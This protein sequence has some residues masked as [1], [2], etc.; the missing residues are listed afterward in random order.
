MTKLLADVSGPGL[1]GVR[2]RV[3]SHTGG[4]AT[5]KE[6]YSRAVSAE[7]VA[8]VQVARDPEA[9]YVL[10]GCDPIPEDPERQ[11]VI[12]TSRA[13]AAYARADWIDAEGYDSETGPSLA[14]D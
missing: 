12:R 11:A 7:P 1:Y 14:V 5:T 6:C 4:S 13:R 3:P 2:G 9:A 8:M 10:A